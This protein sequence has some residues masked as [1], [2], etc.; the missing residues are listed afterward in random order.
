[1]NEKR[2]WFKRVMAIWFIPIRLEGYILL[3][4]FAL[5]FS[6]LFKLFRHLNLK[7]EMGLYIEA[8]ISVPIYLIFL[9]V[10]ISRTR[11]VP[12]DR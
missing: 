7:G 6:M 8:G 1:M 3:G 11:P 10:V 2:Y 9:Y 4:L 5:T 12:R